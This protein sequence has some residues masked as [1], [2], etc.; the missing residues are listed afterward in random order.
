MIRSTPGSRIEWKLMRKLRE[1]D[2]KRDIKFKI[3]NIIVG[4]ARERQYAMVMEDFG[5]E[6]ARS[7]I[8]HVKDPQLRRRI[9]QSSLRE[10]GKL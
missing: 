3:A 1:K 2:K 6:P 9:Y 4:L 5:K 10:H 7:M 8:N